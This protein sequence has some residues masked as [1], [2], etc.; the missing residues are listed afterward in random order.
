MMSNQAIDVAVDIAAQIRELNLCFLHA[1]RRVGDTREVALRYG[2]T[3]EE[4]AT[5]RGASV[6]EVRRMAAP[7][8]LLFRP[9]GRIVKAVLDAE[10]SI[11]G[12]LLNALSNGS[13]G[14]NRGLSPATRSYAP[15]HRSWRSN[16]CA[17][18]Y[19]TPSWRS[20]VDWPF[21][22]SVSFGRSCATTDHVPAHCR[23]PLPS[24]AHAR[25]RSRRRCWC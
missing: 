21:P 9:R 15:R 24:C 1:I 14:G 17:S 19:A 3:D 20:R 23:N 7:G 2:L 10:A 5:V 22:R 18:V 11:D 25:R 16:C 4:V 12:A 6:E 8:V 13:S